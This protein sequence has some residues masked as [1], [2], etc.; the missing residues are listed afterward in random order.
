MSGEIITP[1]PRKV[2]MW[3]N[4]DRVRANQERYAD[5]VRDQPMKR[6]DLVRNVIDRGGAVVVRRVNGEIVMEVLR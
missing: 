3:I 4:N 2:D 5:I 1:D 6:W